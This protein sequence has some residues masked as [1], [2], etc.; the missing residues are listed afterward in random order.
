MEPHSRLGLPETAETELALWFD[1]GALVD[2]DRAVDTW[3][4]AE[5]PP[6]G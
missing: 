5:E 4:M 3:I 1:A 2:Y 6:A